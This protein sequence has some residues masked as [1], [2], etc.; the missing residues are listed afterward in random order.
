MR[1]YALAVA[2]LAC[3]AGVRALGPGQQDRFPHRTHEGL[4]PLC[5]SCHSGILSG[6]ASQRFPTPETCIACHDGR[7]RERVTWSAPTPRASLL[8][9]NHRDHANRLEATGETAECQTCHGTDPSVRMAVERPRPES[10]LTCHAHAAPTHLAPGR[11]CAVCHLPLAR[12]TGLGVDRIAAFPRPASHERDDFTSAHAPGS[13]AERTPCATCHARES[14]ARCHLNADSVPDITALQG[15]PRVAELVRGLAPEYPAP[16]SHR[17][18]AWKE[19]HG[20]EAAARAGTCANC[21]AQAS[22]RSCHREGAL[23]AM[24]ALPAAGPGDPRGVA[25]EAAA[26]VHAPRFATTHAVDGAA[27]EATCASCH[28]AQFCE[29]CHQGPRTPQFHGASFLAR[30]APEAYGNEQDCISCHNAE[31]FCRACHA[32]LGLASRGRGSIGFHTSNAGWL[33]GHGQAARQGMDGCITCHSQASCT[34]CHSAKTGWRISP[35]GPDFD[36]VR[37]RNANQL[38]CR[39]CHFSGDIFR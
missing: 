27:R 28:A 33:L 31:V 23:P 16:A 1:A 4:F 37:M 12:A 15:D 19:V 8:R 22:C 13:P 25:V 18:A 10:C 17:S 5:E 3:A 36:P 20:V 24:A 2:V 21:H 9:F 6:D 30:H 7:E 29:S 14:C 32:G 38:M 35:H 39:R 11:D 34:Q 26:R